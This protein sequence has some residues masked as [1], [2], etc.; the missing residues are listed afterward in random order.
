MNVIM[1]HSVGSDQTNWSKNSLSIGENQ[2]EV[3]CKYLHDKRY[4]S[5]FLD[6][7]LYLNINRFESSKKNVFLTFDDGYLDNFLVAFPILKRYGL[8]ATFF[9]NPEFIDPGSGIRIPKQI[10]NDSTLGYLNWDEIQLMNESGVVDIQSH[11]MSHN[12]YFCSDG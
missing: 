5:H 12:F 9:I 10:F 1:F 4:N 2:F 7:W 3:F 8:K 11:S 6:H